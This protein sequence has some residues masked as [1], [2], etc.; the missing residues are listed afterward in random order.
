MDW[1]D[2]LEML[3]REAVKSVCE[4]KSAVIFSS[5]VDSALVAYAASEMSDVTAY[6]VSMEDAKDREYARMVEKEAKFR[7]KYIE[8][9]PIDLEEAVADVVAKVPEVTPLNVGVGIP[10]YCASKAAAKDGFT[11]ILCGQGGDELFGG[12]WR[13]LECMVK[14]GPDAVAA[15]MEKDWLN[16]YKDNLY[17]DIVMC[18]SNGV[19]L[20]FPYLHKGFS[21]YSRKMPLDL[22]IREGAQDIV[23][24]DINGRKF[25]RKYTLKRL[26]IRMGVPEYLV[27]RVKKAAQYGSGTQKALDKIARAKGYKQ[28]ADAAGRKDYTQMFLEDLKNRM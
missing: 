28:K 26:A 4:S 11:S 10:F 18:K 22:K 16:A 9:A 23:C 19:E 25:A 15:W 17:R 3:F 20:R 21:D 2:D 6:N 27:N 24:D 8:L 14:V 12:Y 13:Y 7:I 5:G 1:L